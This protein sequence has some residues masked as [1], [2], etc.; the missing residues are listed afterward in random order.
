MRSRGTYE[1]TV[2]SMLM[3]QCHTGLKRDCN[4]LAR[5]LSIV[6][7]EDC[8]AANTSFCCGRQIKQQGPRC[9][10]RKRRV[11]RQSKVVKVIILGRQKLAFGR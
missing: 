9:T 11:C 1:E 3:Q 7:I 10:D 5:Q 8:F 2:V 6:W 4:L